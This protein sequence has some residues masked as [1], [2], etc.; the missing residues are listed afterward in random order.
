MKT[1]NYQSTDRACP[2]CNTADTDV[3]DS[4]DESATR[5]KVASEE[6][7]TFY[8]KDR[9]LLVCPECQHVPER[10]N[11]APTTDNWQQFWEQR[12]ERDGRTRVVGSYP[13]AYP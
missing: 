2:Y 13:H 6:D 4:S 11:R 8:E 3:A 5:N 7:I 9:W 12:Q 10:V 1:T